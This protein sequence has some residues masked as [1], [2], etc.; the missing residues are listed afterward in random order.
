MGEVRDLRKKHFFMVDDEYL[1]GYAK[2]CGW[3]ATLVYMALCRHADKHQTCFPSKKL[4]STK[5][6]IS[7]RSIYTAIKTL[8][9]WNIIEVT[10][11]GRKEDGSFRNKIYRLK[12]KSV[13]GKI[14]QATGADGTGKHSPQATDDTHRRHHV[15]NKETHSKGT[16][17][18]ETHNIASS[19][20]LMQF[21]STLQERIRV[22][23]ERNRFKNKS[24]LITEGRKSTLLAE[25]FSSRERC[26]DDSVFG[27]ALDM[28]INYDACNVGYVGKVW[29]NRK[30]GKA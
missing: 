24:R 9:E 21:P 6:L 28:S 4:L 17:N 3:K 11:Q 8:Q 27:Y 2:H 30:A 19:N 13:W 18:K 29:G 20:L 10:E 16:H 1:N 15:P 23:I 22:Y 14:P 25:L 7:E 5:L 26:N 12:D